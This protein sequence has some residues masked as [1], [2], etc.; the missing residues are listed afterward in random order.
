MEA[1]L[2]ATFNDSA[3]A[4]KAIGALLDRGLKNE[5][6]C[7]LSKEPEGNRRDDNIETSEDLEKAGKQGI[8]TTTGADAGVG[9]AKGA[10][11]G[12]GLGAAAAVASLLIPGVGLVIGGG[13][14]ALAIA[15]AAGA[16]AAGAVAGG[17]TGYLKDQG[18]PEPAAADYDDAYNHGSAL[19][20]VHVPSGR[21]T[22]AE[23]IDTLAKYRASNVHTYWTMSN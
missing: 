1:T 9:A 3:M 4:E 21:V 11:L 13:A 14:L 12:L 10:G 22:N 17:V 5:D 8:S 6:I 7:V 23:V 18:V 20:T 19:L 2:Y 15:G 16:T